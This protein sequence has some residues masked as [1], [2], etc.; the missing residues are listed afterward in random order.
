MLALDAEDRL[1]LPV[2][3][4]VKRK[5]RFDGRCGDK[6]RLVRADDVAASRVQAGHAGDG[7]PESDRRVRW[8][9]LVAIEQ[10]AAERDDGLGLGAVPCLPR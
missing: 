5:R 6:A 9:L 3:G 4:H 10:I 8:R 1:P 7:E 2:P